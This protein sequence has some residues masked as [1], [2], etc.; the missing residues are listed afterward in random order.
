MLRLAIA[1]DDTRSG[2][3]RQ[4]DCQLSMRN[5]L[6]AN[7]QS[8][9]RKLVIKAPGVDDV[10]IEQVSMRENSGLF[11]DTFGMPVLLSAGK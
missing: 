6:S 4:L 10:S 11:R 5:P 9:A 1:L 3:I 8:N 2:R 7:N